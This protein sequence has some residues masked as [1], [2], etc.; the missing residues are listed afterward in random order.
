MPSLYEDKNDKYSLNLSHISKTDDDEDEYKNIE[1]RKVYKEDEVEKK[2]VRPGTASK[3]RPQSGVNTA[4][5]KAKNV[6]ISDYEKDTIQEYEEVEEFDEN[7]EDDFY[8]KNEDNNNQEVIK[9]HDDD[10]NQNE[11]NAY[12]EEDEERQP[13]IAKTF[14]LIIECGKSVSKSLKY[15]NIHDSDLLF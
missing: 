5:I 1:K 10:E 4:L 7:F 14:E 15:N 9:F 11:N 2:L 6:D 3:I 12:T 8:Y 13:E